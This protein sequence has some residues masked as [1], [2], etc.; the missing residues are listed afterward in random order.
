MNKKKLLSLLGIITIAATS[1]SS[2]IYNVSDYKLEMNYKDNFRIIQLTDVHF[3]IEMNFKREVEHLKK[4]IEHASNPDLIILTGD[5]FMNANKG[6]VDLLFSTLDSYDIPWAITWGNHDLQGDYDHFYLNDQVRKTKNA[7]FVDYKDDVLT[8][9][10]NY[11]IDLKEGDNVKYRLYI[12]DSGSYNYTVGDIG[13]DYGIIEQ[14]QIDHIKAIYEDNPAPGLAFFH[15]PLLEFQDAWDESLKEEHD[16]FGE[17]N[18][19]SCPGYANLGQYEAFKSC[20]I[21]GCFVG[22]D[23]INDSTI[24]FNDEMLLSY[25][26]KASDVIYHDESMIGYK[27]I[28]LPNN[29]D[30][31]MNDFKNYV[32][33]VMVTY[34]EK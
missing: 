11:F 2:R 3:G 25:G 22:H 15:I 34:D 8:G 17:N 26:V 18:E 1:C 12:V 32:K 21:L 27:E 6:I 9:D 10:T 30:S 5:N 31:F 13:Y 20:N 7:L 28:I 33:N 23:H 16:Y 14:N 19:D 29:V 24:K 4:M